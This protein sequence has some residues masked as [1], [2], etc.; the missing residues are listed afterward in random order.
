VA[1]AD[2]LLLLRNF[3]HQQAKGDT[4]GDGVWGPL[5]LLLYQLVWHTQWE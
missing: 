3:W 4:S 5:D 1:D 2:D